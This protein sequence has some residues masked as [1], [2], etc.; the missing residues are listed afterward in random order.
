MI[1]VSLLILGT[2]LIP[3]AL[4]AEVHS[5]ENL[6]Y[7]DRNYNALYES[8]IASKNR[9]LKKE[10]PASYMVPD[11]YSYTLKEGEDIW[12]LIAKTSL[13][14]DAIATLN[15]IDFIG[16]L[17]Q[18][19]TVFLPDTIGIFFDAERQAEQNNT[20]MLA[21]KYA[22]SEGDILKVT[23]PQD[24]N[25]TFLFLPE[26]QLSFLERTYLTGVVFYSPLMGIETSKFGKRADPLINEE[27]FHSGI[28]ITSEEGKKVHAARWGRIVYAGTSDGYGNLVVIEHELGY[29]TLYG[30][31]Q[32]ILV[33]IDD[34]VDSGQ[35]IGRVGATGRT[36]G[37]HLHF[38]IHREEGSLNPE[39]IPYFLEL[40]HT[41]EQ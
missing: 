17:R 21:E 20:L 30:H 4:H 38:E 11:I 32:E 35:I 36:T 7:T 41:A 39:N 12:T 26:V 1:K 22:I 16:M 24:Q 2:L 14:I 3:L 18:D 15:R 25:R 37:P 29:Y 27:A 34:N 28:D 10:R 5:I 19:V 13:T 33:E 6:N 31:L 8:T 9:L 40:D 23:D